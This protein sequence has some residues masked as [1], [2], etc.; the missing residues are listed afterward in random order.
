MKRFR[1]MAATIV[2]V[3]ALGA[4]VSMAHAESAPFFSINGTR[5]AAGKTHNITAHAIKS[6][7][8]VTPAAGLNITCTKLTVEK[9][10]LLGSEAGTE[11]K[12]DQTS[13]YEG[14]KL[15]TGNGAPK[16]H[17]A[18]TEKGAE[19]STTITT[20]ALHGELVENVE[21]G[22]GGKKLEEL[23]TPASGSVF[24][25]IDFGGEGCEVFASKVTGSTAVEVVTDPGEAAIELPGPTPEA[26][27]FIVR[28]PATAITE[29][30][31]VSGGT[32]KIVKVEEE[33]LT[34]TSCQ[35]GTALV[36]LANAKFE[37]ET[38]AKWSPLP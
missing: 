25:T 17:L 11:G 36:L 9:G 28:F 22:K 2:M 18:A 21:G 16:C 19:T 38:A 35:A 1:L 5:L 13:K 37:P 26:T 32:G 24:V 8:L 20:N 14:C 7:G 30:W 3:I 6:F 10:A 33:F 12:V 23:Y 15:E 34:N 4:V 27:S 31:L 29:V